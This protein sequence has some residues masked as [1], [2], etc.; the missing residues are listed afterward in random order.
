M[1]ENIEKIKP[2]FFSIREIDLTK[3][4]LDIKLPFNWKY[5]KIISNYDDIG[6][7]LQDKNEINV[8]L[9]LVT[10]SSKEGY[11]LVFSCAQT[12][13]LF[14]KEEEAK[15]LLFEEKVHELKKLFETQSL[16]KLKEIKLLNDNEKDTTQ[17]RLVGEG[18]EERSEGN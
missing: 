13:I 11:E 16:E 6:F 9:S 7:I 4:C 3:V 8:L 12:I 5:E 15:K 1:Y 17:F 10:T 18:I 14:N 2:Y